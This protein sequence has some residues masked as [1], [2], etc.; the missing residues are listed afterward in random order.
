[1]LYGFS[2]NNRVL[3]RIIDLGF[4]L[5]FA[6][7]L[8]AGV[9]LIEKR[10]GREFSGPFK[11]VDG[12]TLETLA[13]DRLRLIDIDAPEYGQ[14][15]RGGSVQSQ[16]NWPC[17]RRATIYLRQLVSSGQI[18]CYSQGVDYYARDL[19]RCIGDKA[20]INAKMVSAGWAIA[21]DGYFDEQARAHKAK[22]GIWSG[23]FIK[24]EK[25]RK[26]DKAD[27][28]LRTTGSI[29]DRQPGL[30]AA[31]SKRLWIRL[32]GWISTLFTA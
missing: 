24:P 22:R 6:I 9:V 26:A 30:L 13:G 23:S 32:N 17:G 1:M 18:R 7:L 29:G 28:D 12:D 3:R 25:W 27:I 4:A 8:L 31:W 21:T 15:C 14:T 19:V 2:K 10:G 16:R 11:I 5:G 20:D